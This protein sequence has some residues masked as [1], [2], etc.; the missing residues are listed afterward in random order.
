MI[1]NVQQ[2]WVLWLVALEQGNLPNA[3]IPNVLQRMS[4]SHTGGGGA[5]QSAATYSEAVFPF[6]IPPDKKIQ[7]KAKLQ[8]RIS[9][10]N[11]KQKQ[12]T[13]REMNFFFFCHNS[14]HVWLI[15]EFMCSNPSCSHFWASWFVAATKAEFYSFFI[16]I[17]F[18]SSGFTLQE[19]AS[20]SRQDLPPEGSTVISSD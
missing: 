9:N 3:V 11:W 17:I 1:L 19:E 7:W 14:I 18:I 8:P 2:H 13:I 16:I 10:M 5:L 12:F 15:W 20:P 4:V 6:R